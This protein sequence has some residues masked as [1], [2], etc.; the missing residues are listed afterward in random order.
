V[1]SPP[2]E[3]GMG[4]FEWIGTSPEYVGPA[5]LPALALHSSVGPARKAARLR[6]LTDYLRAQLAE[7]VPTARFYSLPGEGMTCGLC[8]FELPGFDSTTLKDRLLRDHQ[9]LVQAMV[10]STRTPE[11]KGIRVSPNV[12][13]TPAELD[14][15]VAALVAVTR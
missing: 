15:L 5:M 6:Y 7:R 10:G 12:Y 1:P 2:H 11:I 9:I 3:K 4:R 13:T 8:T 14:R